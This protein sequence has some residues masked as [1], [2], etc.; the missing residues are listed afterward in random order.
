MF[1]RLAFFSVGALALAYALSAPERVH[2]QGMRGSMRMGAPMRM[3]MQMNRTFK[4]G[5]QS[6]FMRP[7]AF[8]PGFN[9][10]LFRP[11]F[12]DGRG[13]F[14]RFEDRFEKRVRFGSFDR[15]EDRLENRLRFGGSSQRLNSNSMFFD[16]R[17]GGMF[18]MSPFPL[19]F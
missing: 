1:R 3:P 5:F 6:G 10:M 7:G 12:S 15:F 14:D 2:G 19:G 11:S 16:P 8:D 13:T 18:F 4:P 17:L 9:S